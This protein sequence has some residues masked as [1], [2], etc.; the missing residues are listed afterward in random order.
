VVLNVVGLGI[1]HLPNP[2]QSRLP[3]VLRGRA[4]RLSLGGL[5]G[6]GK[7]G[8]RILIGY[9]ATSTGNADSTPVQRSYI[10][11]GVGA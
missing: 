11:S 7:H 5:S 8:P 1:L 2:L 4:I 3:S 6:D 10:Y 9:A